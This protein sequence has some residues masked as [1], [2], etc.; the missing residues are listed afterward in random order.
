MKPTEHLNVLGVV[1]RDA[2]VNGVRLHYVR[3]GEQTADPLVLLRGFPQGWLMWRMILP[4]LAE[5]HNSTQHGPMFA[6]Q[7]A[8]KL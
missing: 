8:R 1:H 5:V 7:R 4:A 6:R 3:T 2:M